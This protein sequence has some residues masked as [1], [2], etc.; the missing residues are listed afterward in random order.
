MDANPKIKT[1]YSFVAATIMLDLNTSMGN[2]MVQQIHPYACQNL[3]NGNP[4]F[5]RLYDQV[6]RENTPHVLGTGMAASPEGFVEAFFAWLKS[7]S[8]K[9]TDPNRKK[10]ISVFSGDAKNPQTGLSFK[11][12]VTIYFDMEQ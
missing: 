7:K 9:I 10:K 8:I 3:R 4:E 12:C 6:E 11:W 5:S 2:S 1:V